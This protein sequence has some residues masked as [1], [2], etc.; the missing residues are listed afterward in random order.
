MN[1]KTAMDEAL[2][3]LYLPD[4]ALAALAAGAEWEYTPDSVDGA[5]AD[6]YWCDDCGTWHMNWSVWG[7]RLDADGVLYETWTAVDTDGDWSFVDEYPYGEFDHAEERAAVRER[8]RSYARWVVL[9]GRDPVGE[10]SSFGRTLTRTIYTVQFS[11]SIVGPRVVRVRKAHGKYTPLSEQPVEVRTFL[12]DV[13]EFTDIDDM[14][15]RA[16]GLTWT[17]N[18]ATFEISRYE[19][20]TKAEI[21]RRAARLLEESR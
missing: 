13:G 3:S 18:R 10:F 7:L 11:P 9:Q 20:V 14:R 12:A 16:H 6:V 4:E 5:D 1:L 21:R 15:A 8:W 17:G 2:A 19:K